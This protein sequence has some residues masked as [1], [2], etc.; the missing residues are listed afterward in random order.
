MLWLSVFIPELSLQ[1]ALRG[2]LGHLNTMPLVLAEG[3]A[4]RPLVHAANEAASALEIVPG[5]PVA[6]AQARAAGL[7][8]LPREVAKEQAVLRQLA[9]WL[10]QF[11]PMATLES[12]GVSLEVSGSLRLFGGLAPLARRVRLGLR[13]LGFHAVLG[14]APVP[15]AAWLL[16]RMAHER[17]GVRMCRDAALL[18]A[19]LSEVPLH[20][21]DWPLASMAALSALGLTRVRD[22]LVQPRAAFRKR[23]GEALADDLDRALGRLSDPREAYIVPQRFDASIDLVFDTADAARLTRFAERLLVALE[24][25]LRASGAAAT[26]VALDFRHGRERVTEMRF[27]SRTPLRAASDW[28]K[29]IRERLAARPLDAPVIAIAL[30]TESTS[31]WSGETQ[32]WLPSHTTHRER[33]EG[34]LDRI[35]SRLGSPCVFTIDAKGDHRPESAWAAAAHPAQPCARRPP[36]RITPHARPLM[37]LTQPKSLVTLDGAPQH[38]GALTLVAGPERIETGWWDGKPVARDYFVAVNRQHEVCWVYRDYRFGRQWFL[39]GVFA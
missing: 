15:R 8:I 6:A 5:M 26:A 35:A 36:Q 9:G 7:V 20:H 33:W 11:T 18:A 23:L 28:I 27:G 12:Q 2:T 29:L 25:H 16:A 3:P 17:A 10:T 37:L 14:V 30:R 19:R 39:H 32:S 1:V 34:L 13:A 24:G 22:V 38:R 21:F 4:N 31:A